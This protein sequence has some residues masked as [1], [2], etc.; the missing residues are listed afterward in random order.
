MHMTNKFAWCG[1]CVEHNEFW[2]YE[3]GNVWYCKK[4]GYEEGY[5]KKF[6]PKKKNEFSIKRFMRAIGNK[7][8]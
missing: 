5:A 7:R 1:M 3:N 8:R 6:P 2:R 4:C